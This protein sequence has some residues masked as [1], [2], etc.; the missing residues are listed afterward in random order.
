MTAHHLSLSGF[1]RERE[2][3]SRGGFTLIESMATILIL[4]LMLYAAVSGLDSLGST[5]RLTAAQNL[6]SALEEA[7]SEAMKMSAA[8]FM[9]LRQKPDEFGV[10]AYREYGLFRKK[11]DA[12]QVIW[13]PL[14]NGIVL[15]PGNLPSVSTGTNVLEIPSR[16]PRQ[17]GFTGLG[18]LDDQEFVMIVFGDL[19]EVTF[20]FAQPLSPGAPSTPGPYYLCVAEAAP[21]AANAPPDNMQLIEIRA[22]SG[23][24]QLLP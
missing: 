3:L 12:N 1:C 15:W 21:A 11:A 16:T 23:R 5:S 6:V 4:S 8:S 9:A 2:T 20:P 19:G 17:M 24:S 7:R 10:S 14:P 18:D 13:R 22:A